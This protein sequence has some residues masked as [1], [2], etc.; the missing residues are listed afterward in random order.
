MMFI[1]IASI[2][3]W[4]RQIYL[5]YAFPPYNPQMPSSWHPVRCTIVRDI[6]LHFMETTQ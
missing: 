3:W 4:V 5:H 2:L 6:R 1:A